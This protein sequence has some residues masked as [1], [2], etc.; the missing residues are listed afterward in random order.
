MS[1]V[2]TQYVLQGTGTSADTTKFNAIVAKM[3]ARGG[4]HILIAGNV[5]INASTTAISVPGIIEGLPGSVLL[6]DGT[7][8]VVNVGSAGDVF[9]G[10]VVMDATASFANQITGTTP[11]SITAGDYVCVWADNQVDAPFTPDVDGREYRPMELHRI[12]KAA[13][14]LGGNLS[15]TDWEIDCGYIRDPLSTAP[16]YNVLSM[17]D[18]FELRNVTYTTNPGGTPSNSAFVFGRVAGLRIE[19]C[20]SLSPA[21]GQVA[22]YFCHDVDVSDC[23]F[24]EKTDPNN[25]SRLAGEGYDLVISVCSIVHI[26]RNTFGFTRHGFTTGFR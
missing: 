14:V 25:A 23:S 26:H 24:Q 17:V 3:N 2:N 9:G 11:A 8:A 13:A 20:T 5:L 21:T 1:A 18:G 7:S 4:G 6:F 22:I 16:R 15:D 19:K 10:G 12:V